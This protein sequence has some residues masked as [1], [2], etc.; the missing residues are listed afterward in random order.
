MSAVN[1]S[2]NSELNPFG[3]LILYVVLIG[4]VDFI[5][6]V[7][8]E[9]LFYVVAGVLTL[10]LWGG[11]IRG[12]RSDTA[13]IFLIWYIF[14]FL[15]GGI[16]LIFDLD[17]LSVYW[18]KT[19]PFILIFLIVVAIAGSILY[20]LSTDF[21]SFFLVST[22]SLGSLAYSLT[23]FTPP[24][25]TTKI[26]QWLFE[27]STRIAV[28]FYFFAALVF[29]GVAIVLTTDNTRWPNQY[30]ARAASRPIRPAYGS[31]EVLVQQLEV[32]VEVI[33]TFLDLIFRRVL[34]WLFD[35][36]WHWL[37]E[38]PDVALAIFFDMIDEIVVFI[39]S[40][41]VQIPLHFVAVYSL[42]I[43]V[44]A[45]RGYV[46]DGESLLSFFLAI[47]ITF[48]ASSLCFI[49]GVPLTSSRFETSV[50]FDWLA[51]GIQLSSPHALL[52]F[53]GTFWSLIGLTRFFDIREF[54]IGFFTVLMSTVLI[55]GVAMVAIGRRQ[56]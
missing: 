16:F 36:A 33:A 26:A 23:R 40:I 6:V 22:L 52:V 32:V 35:C 9:W 42:W 41:L 30:P 45:L 55:V 24:E 21:L 27:N 49:I 5:A 34:L 4:V 18:E 46:Y 28:V 56:S 29:L 15:V 8:Q 37:K 44:V 14:A 13:P 7:G 53:I 10:L 20:I 48:F 2:E 38:F 39:R 31:L 51:V 3:Y 47:V 19:W 11:A 25:S 1:N 54:S 12:A 43:F 17:P 50:I